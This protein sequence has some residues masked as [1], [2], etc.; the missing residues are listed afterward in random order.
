MHHPA[1]T[2][3]SRDL[4]ANRVNIAVP[5]LLLKYLFLYL[6]D[7]AKERKREIFTFPSFRWHA[8]HQARLNNVKSP[9]GEGAWCSKTSQIGEYIQVNNQN[10]NHSHNHDH[11]YDQNHNND[12]NNNGLIS[13]PQGGSSMLN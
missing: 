1:S 10:H 12:N 13:I 8:P 3:K 9:K 4:H 2:S 5:F 6:H 7:E 11:D